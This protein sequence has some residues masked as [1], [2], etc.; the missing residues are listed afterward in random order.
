MD[1]LKQLG[2]TAVKAWDAVMGGVKWLE[3]EAGVIKTWL[4]KEEPSVVAAAQ[5][6]IADGEKGAAF[7]AQYEGDALS[8]EISAAAP[9]VEEAVIGFL[10]GFL[11]GNPAQALETNAGQSL[12][13][14]GVNVLKSLI[15]VNVTKFASAMG[16]GQIAAAATAAPTAAPSAV[17]GQE[18]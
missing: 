16:Q 17:A 9:D 2:Q 13:A 12:L 5:K 15:D 6:L 18:D 1:L 7:L 14:D 8:Q 4:E 3:T 10:S 11:G